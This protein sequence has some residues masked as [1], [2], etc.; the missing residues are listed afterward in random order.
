MLCTRV[1]V[2]CPAVIEFQ[3][4]IPAKLNTTW[5]QWYPKWSIKLGFYCSSNSVTQMCSTNLH[6]LITVLNITVY[7]T[8]DH[9]YFYAAPMHS[10]AT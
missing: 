10:A 2:Q 9:C 8:S 5:G 7:I 1:Q 4:N 3:T 6:N